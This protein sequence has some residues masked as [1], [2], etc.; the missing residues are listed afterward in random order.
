MTTVEVFDPAMCCSTGVCGPSV[1][2][3]LATFAA[4]LGW[5]A[6]QGVPVERHSLSQEPGAFA[7]SDLVRQLLV[8]HGEKALPAVVVD[9]ELRS[10]GRY[11]TQAE[12]AT[13]ALGNGTPDGL[14]PATVTG[15]GTGTGDMEAEVVGAECSDGASSLETTSSSC[16]GGAASATE[17]ALIPAPSATSGC[18]G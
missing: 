2:P 15:T 5:L 11:P 8:E 17:V 14:D 9:G 4:D 1:D 16:C 7:E 6:H 10:S 12:L 3:A 13:W 18:C